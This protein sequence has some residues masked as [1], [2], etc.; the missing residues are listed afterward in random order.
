MQMNDS[1]CGGLVQQCHAIQ[2]K[3]A[4]TSLAFLQQQSLFF[5][6]SGF[7]G[8]I[9]LC[10]IPYLPQIGAIRHTDANFPPGVFISDVLLE[11]NLKTTAVTIE[12]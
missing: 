4:S 5:R 2:F 11:K 7:E 8:F 1:R 3:M 6:H 10:R 9:L 12:E